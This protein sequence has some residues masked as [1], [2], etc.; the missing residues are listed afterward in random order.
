MEDRRPIVAGEHW[1]NDPEDQD[2]PAAT[3]YLSLLVGRPAAK[4]LAK[5]LQKQDGVV[6]YA[7][8]DLL[9]ASHLPLLGP[10]DSEVAADLEKVSS[11]VKLSP[12]LLV[13]GAPLWVA[14]GYHRVCASYHIDEKAQVPCRIVP[15]SKAA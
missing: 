5:A 2:F 9:R 7:A 12:V 14:D 1:K 15:R 3:S 4:K 6:L 11:G 8:K 13:E 10:D